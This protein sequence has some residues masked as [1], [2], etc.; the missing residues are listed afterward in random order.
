MTPAN[1]LTICGVMIGVVYFS[2]F[3]AVFFGDRTRR[4]IVDYTV[5]SVLFV[6]V[7]LTDAFGP[8]IAGA[9]ATRIVTYCALQGGLIALLYGFAKV[10][11][12]RF[13]ALVAA[14]LF[15]GGLVAVLATGMLPV[16]SLTRLVAVHVWHAGLAAWIGTRLVL[17][18]GDGA[19][20][21]P[22]AGLF[23]LLAAQHVF[24]P[25]T[26]LVISL[27]G[28]VA[29]GGADALY[30]LV[31][32]AMFL[33]VMTGMGATMF[34]KVMA[35][36]VFDWRRAAECDPLTGLLNRRGFVAAVN[37][38][39]SAHGTTAT[40]IALIDIDHFKAINDRYGHARGD[41]VLAGLG[42][43]LRLH[44]SGADVCGRFGG[45]EFIVLLANTGR[46]KTQQS[47][48]SLRLTIER[49][50]GSSS[51][52]DRVVTV[53][54]GVASWPGSGGLEDAVSQADLALYAAK[55]TGRNRVRY[56]QLP[57]SH[58]KS[59]SQEPEISQG[60]LALST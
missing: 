37:A 40:S 3:L 36:Q 21:L 1:I 34:L 18:R 15:A 53:S 47:M 60:R 19:Y 48:D 43:L 6:T 5:A 54:I 45:E 56:F 16:T 33:V 38:V 11:R 10:Y 14:S 44:F 9:Y 59:P 42:R 28:D 46:E 52:L 51:N 50:L 22:V 26:A 32:N 12:F 29:D 58:G 8:A 30:N 23:Y 49:E 13:P 24:R 27:S 35:D 17:A 25:V 55:R 39:V 31:A 2:L 4:Y 57:S 20:S 41:D 7:G